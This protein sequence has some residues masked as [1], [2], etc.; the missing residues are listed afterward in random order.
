[1]PMHCDD[2]LIGSERVEFKKE[3]TFEDKKRKITSEK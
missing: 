2:R 3:R 1:M